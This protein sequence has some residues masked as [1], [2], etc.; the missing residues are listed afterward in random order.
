MS[1]IGTGG[2]SGSGGTGGTAG[3][4]GTGGTSGT[5]GASG[6]GGS[7]GDA[8]PDGSATCTATALDTPSIVDPGDGTFAVWTSPVTTDLGDGGSST[9]AFEFYAGIEPNLAT[10]FDLAAGHQANYSSCAVC[11]RLVTTDSSGNPARVFFQDGGSVTLTVDP[12]TGQHMLGSISNLGMQEVTIDSTSF[13]S[14]PVA[15]GQCL[16]LGDIALDADTVP[17]GWTCNH[18]AYNDGTNCD[19]KCGTPDPDCAIANAPV[20]GCSGAQVCFNDACADKPAND[21]C[22]TAQALTIGTPVTGTTVGATSNYDAGLQATSCTGSAQPGPDVVY[23]VDLA[24]ATSYKFALTNADPTYDASLSLVGP[25]A[26]AVCDVSPV[27]CLAGSDTG[28]NGGEDEIFTYTTTAAGTYYVIVDSYSATQAGGYTVT[29][30][31]N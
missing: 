25:G 3:T 11:L 30:T 18:A 10:T 4:S 2:T 22:Q 21:T 20:V 29:V 24:N 6:T 12:I 13:K 9:F 14:T 5:A 8:G 15:G 16:S 7:A 17:S 23:S 27:V 28:V 26:P 31:A 19:C 1:D